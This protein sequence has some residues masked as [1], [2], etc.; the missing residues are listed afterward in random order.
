MEVEASSGGGVG[1]RR[2][3]VEQQGQ[4]GAL[5]EVGR[6]G[7]SADEV[8]GLGEELLGEGRAMTWRRPRHERT[9]GATG[10]SIVGDDT[11]IIGP[12]QSSG[13]LQLFVKRTT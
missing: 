13:T 10:Q 7:A 6:G 5:P 12:T 11:C 2:Q 9:P 3:F 8:S 4:A 1:K